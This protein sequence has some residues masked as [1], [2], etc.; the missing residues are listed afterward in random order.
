VNA[1]G[2]VTAIALAW[3]LQY[4]LTWLQIRHYRAAIKQLVVRYRQA[5]GHYLFTGIARKALGSGAIVLIIVDDNHI[6]QHVQ[7]LTGFTVFAKFKRYLDYEGM[8][9]E[10]VLRIAEV[11]LQQRRRL[12][13][14]SQSLA[15]AFKMATENS[16]RSLSSPKVDGLHVA[17]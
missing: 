2:V 15:R 7:V 16:L 14:K 1:I 5:E 13:S 8:R 6:I 3:L 12:S 4:A 17:E 11:T 10:E 9:L